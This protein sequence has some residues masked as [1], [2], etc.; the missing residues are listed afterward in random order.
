M[1]KP[2]LLLLCLTFGCERSGGTKLVSPATPATVSLEKPAAVAVSESASAVPDAD[3]FLKLKLADFVAFAAQPETWKEEGDDLICSGKPKGYLYSKKSYR[4]FT[5]RAEYRFIPTEGE[6]DPEKLAASNSGF[7]L[8]IQEPHKVWPRSY[9]AQ[10]K[11]LEM[12]TLKANG[13]AATLTIQD[14]AAA[15]ETARRP[16][17]EWNQVEIQSKKG[18]LT[19]RLNGT[20]ICESE[21]SELT[22]GVIGLQSE[23]YPVRFRK[24]LI[25]EE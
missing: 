9:E 4:N 13:G 19:T 14:D 24:L 22:S 1:N 5:W 25:R 20:L 17:G 2:F 6:T 21:P 7:M 10:G 8:H 3:G 15:R 12:C 23:N 11:H 16:V 18:K